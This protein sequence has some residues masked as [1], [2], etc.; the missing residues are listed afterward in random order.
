MI[1]LHSGNFH[2][3]KCRYLLPKPCIK[4]RTR[5]ELIT[6][7]LGGVGIDVLIERN[8]L[9]LR[10]YNMSTHIPRTDQVHAAG[11]K[12][13]ICICILLSTLMDFIYLFYLF[14]IS[15]RYIGCR[16][17]FGRSGIRTRSGN[18]SGFLTQYLHTIPA[19]ERYVGIRA[20]SLFSSALAPSGLDSGMYVQYSVHLR[21]TYRYTRRYMY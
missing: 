1:G 18:H 9:D 15:P 4:Y 7:I 13:E 12:R 2:M 10:V 16:E 3:A 8:M 6:G 19:I 21:D 17:S 11:R 14:Q 5:L 20:V